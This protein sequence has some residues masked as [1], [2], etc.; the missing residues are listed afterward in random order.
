ME[1]DD[2][3]EES[4]HLIRDLWTNPQGRDYLL[5]KGI[6]IIDTPEYD[7]SVTLNDGT[8]TNIHGFIG[9]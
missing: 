1:L 5:S 6:K 4:I 8:E 7:M 3:Y 2:L 9:I